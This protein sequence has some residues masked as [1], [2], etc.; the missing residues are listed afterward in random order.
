MVQNI[1]H[2]KMKIIAY[3][4]CSSVHC[5]GCTA[6][7]QINI[8]VDN[9]RVGAWPIDLPKIPEWDEHG[10][11]INSVDVDGNPVRPIF[12]TD[13]FAVDLTCSDCFFK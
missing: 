12:S 5:P 8:K 4:Y 7:D 10:V 1:E 2:I 3:T 6:C 9:A 11:H 13:A